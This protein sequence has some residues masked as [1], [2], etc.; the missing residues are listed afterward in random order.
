MSKEIQVWLTHRWNNDG[1]FSVTGQWEADHQQ[2]TWQEGAYSKSAPADHV[3]LTAED[4]IAHAEKLRAENIFRLRES[5]VELEKLDF[6]SAL[7][8]VPVW[9]ALARR[10]GWK[11]P[12]SLL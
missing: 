5:I 9:H 8:S 1:I 10:A 11:P 7:Q 3:F 2:F 6:S 12:G 4:A